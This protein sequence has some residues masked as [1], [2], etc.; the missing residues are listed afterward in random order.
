MQLHFCGADMG[1]YD[2]NEKETRLLRLQAGNVSTS[3]FEM[4]MVSS[5]HAGYDDLVFSIYVN[6]R[7]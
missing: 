6:G 1:W 3:H 2:V 4:V 7:Q 5:D